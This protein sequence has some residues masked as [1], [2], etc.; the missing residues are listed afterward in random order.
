MGCPGEAMVLYKLIDNQWVLDFEMTGNV[1]CRIKKIKE[2]RELK[3][4]R[5][6]DP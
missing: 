4:L 1:H 3:K 5:A 6:A 2:L